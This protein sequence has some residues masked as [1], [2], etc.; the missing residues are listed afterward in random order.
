MAIWIKFPTRPCI[1]LAS[2]PGLPS[3]LFLQPW[4]K[5]RPR[6]RGGKSCEGRPGYEASIHLLK[7]KVFHSL[8]LVEGLGTRLISFALCLA[9][10][11]LSSNYVLSSI[12]PTYFAL[13]SVYAY[14]VV[15]NRLE[16]SKNATRK[17]VASIFQGKPIT[18]THHIKPTDAADRTTDPMT[19]PQGKP[20]IPVQHVLLA[21]AGPR[22]RSQKKAAKG[23]GRR[24][25]RLP[26]RLQRAVPLLQKVITNH[27][28]VLECNNYLIVYS[29]TLFYSSLIA[30]ALQDELITNLGLIGER[31]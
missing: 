30:F 26:P 17:L 8:F 9:N 5:T 24:T 1:H 13:C 19:L 2:Y 25:E 10:N 22:T 11:T 27:R 7:S 20:V 28:C 21:D 23:R 3:Q 29:P 15:L 18:A 12:P 31:E 4:K 6:L 14:T 16:N